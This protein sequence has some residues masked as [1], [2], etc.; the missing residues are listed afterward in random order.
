[1]LGVLTNQK[2]RNILIIT[3]IILPACSEVLVFRSYH[4]RNKPHF[5]PFTYFALTGSLIIH[6]YTSINEPLRP[7]DRL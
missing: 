2:R 1:M 7:G 6:Y 5:T 4:M 3:I